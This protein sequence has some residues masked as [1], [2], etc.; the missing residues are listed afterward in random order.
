MSLVQKFTPPSLEAV[1]PFPELLLQTAQA[2]LDREA[3]LILRSSLSPGEGALDDAALTSL[4]WR[5]IL[6][7]IRRRMSD[8]VETTGHTARYLTEPPF[9]VGLLA[10]SGY[11]YFV[12]LTAA[13]MLRWTVLLISTRN[14]PSAIESLMQSI[15]GSVLLIGDGVP[16]GPRQIEEQPYSVVR[17]SALEA[18]PN[19]ETGADGF[20]DLGVDYG[21]QSSDW[22]DEIDKYCIYLHT[23][24]TTG[25]PKPIGY[26]HT[27]VYHLCT[28]GGGFAVSYPNIIGVGGVITFVEAQDTMSATSHVRHMRLLRHRKPDVMV[29]SS[30]LE[31]LVSGEERDENIRVLLDMSSVLFGGSPLS[32]AVGDLLSRSGVRITNCFGQTE[33]G[34]VSSFCYHEDNAGPNWP[35]IRLNDAAYNFVFEPLEDG[36][37]FYSLIVTPGVMTPPVL[38][39][40]DPVGFRT[41]DR[42]L[43]AAGRNDDVTVLSNGEKTDNVQLV[44]LLMS[45]PLVARAI[46]FG[47]GRFMNGTL[48]DPSPQTYSQI[49]DNAT[50]YLDSLW[51][52]IHNNV[53]T[54]VPQHSRIIRPLIILAKPEK[55]FLLNDKG[56][57][58]GQA[59]LS[60]Y[61]E[62]IETAYKGVEE[63]SGDLIIS[64]VFDPNDRASIQS[65]IS[66]VL[67]ETLGR[68]IE[69]DEDFFAGGVD[70]LHAIQLR[71]IITSTL[72][73]VHPESGEGSNMVL[74]RDIVFQYPTVTLLSGY[75]HSLCVS[76]HDINGPL[77][78]DADF[79]YIVEQNVA[80]YTSNLPHHLPGPSHLTTGR[81]DGDV[82]VVTG[83]TGSLGSA[84]VS[85]LLEKPN[86]RRIY[87]LNRVQ[88]S[89][90]FE[91]RHETSFTEKGLDSGAL[92]KALE[93]GKAIFVEMDLTKNDL[94]IVEPLRT[95]I[96]SEATH[97]VHIAWLLNFKLILSSFK[98]HLLG[99]LHLINFALSSPLA[100]PPHF[101]FL[102]S[103]SAVGRY[104]TL[105]T[106]PEASSAVPERP[107]HDPHVSLPQGYAQAKYCAERIIEKVAE[108]RPELK[109]CV[110]RSGQIS[111]TEKTGWWARSEYM[112]TL[113]RLSVKLGMVPE[114]LPDVRWLPVNIAAEIL[115]AQIDHHRRSGT[116]S[117]LPTTG[118]ENPVFYHLENA[119]STPWHIVSDSIISYANSQ[120]QPS[121]SIRIGN[122]EGNDATATRRINTVPMKEWLQAATLL[123]NSHRDHTTKH[124]LTKATN[125]KETGQASH[126]LDFYEMYVGDGGAFMPRLDVQRTKEA[127]GELVEYE[128]GDETVKKYVEKACALE[129]LG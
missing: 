1:L 100:T 73:R 28:T 77:V 74:P 7:D 82:Y 62:E 39:N 40:E 85:Y 90:S 63:G 126:L 96:L 13:L 109:A 86:V 94:G 117:T 88:A 52:H 71:S 3:V 103:I 67:H 44:S 98:P 11:D 89:T 58:K 91:E 18:L 123:S 29:A 14:S 66:S 25:H 75:I 42:L 108:Q 51:S 26:A 101:T 27:H 128:I 113:M 99:L 9:N 43:R 53:N 55:P 22:S 80:E 24:G 87:L 76:N 68:T 121:Q 81:L 79:S 20:D 65:Y 107:I 41:S 114:D 46:I 8:L 16:M 111:G 122:S 37:P 48:I 31:D 38:N 119:K 115:Y 57:V 118:T 72:K 127:A 104:H 45:S 56:T 129:S 10:H 49:L 54:V 64:I 12:S 97:I 36:S 2:H 19:K 116:P 17:L 6:A 105:H 93:S 23:S 59:T 95:Q 34:L 15:E 83:T 106:T 84:F 30:V 70:S 102:S 60:R 4:T 47:T 33:A 78:K 110:V 69:A 112:P 61:E 50:A 120:S 124:N 125:D 21:R 35:Y 92:K 5:Q 32:I